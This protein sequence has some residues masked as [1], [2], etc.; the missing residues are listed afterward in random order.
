MIETGAKVRVHQRYPAGHIRAPHYLRGKI[1]TIER[2][3]GP[4]KNPER[5]AY[6]LDAEDR[7]LLRVRF[8]MAEIWG[9]DAENS[10]DTID[11]EIYEHWLEPVDAA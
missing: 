5:L 10:S 7:H 1:G 11:A 6:G 8:S 9:D 3:L 2:T 4:F